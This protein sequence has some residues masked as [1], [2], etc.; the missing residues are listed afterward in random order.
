MRENNRENNLVNLSATESAAL[1]ERAE[2]RLPGGVNS[3]VRAF[4]GVGGH[5]RFIASAKGSRIFDED[6]NSYIDYVGSWGPALFGHGDENILEAVV[7]SAARG[8]SFGAPTRLEVEMAETLCEMIP[9][10]DMVRMVNS[11]TE[12]VMST[13]RLARGFTGRDLIVK[14][15]GCYHGHSDSMLVAAGSGAMTQ[16]VPDSLGVPE[17]AAKD[18]LTLPYNDIREIEKCFDKFGENISS[19]IVEPVA[20]NMGVVL[21]EEGFLQALRDITARHGAL[22]IFDEVITGFRLSAGGAQEYFSVSPDLATFGKIV[23][24][25]MPVGAYGGRADIMKC[26]APLGGVYQAGTL[27][28]NPVAM[29]AGLAALKKIKARGASLYASLEQKAEALAS[30]LELAAADCGID[31]RAPRTVGL[32][33]IF[34]TENTPLNRDMVMNCDAS[35]Y[36]KFFHGMLSRGVYFAPSAYEAFFLSDAHSAED[37]G[38]TIGAAREVFEEMRG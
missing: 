35:L 25:G 23:G 9:S 14:F 37:I 27:S 17:G 4:R 6:G 13:I 19:V 7:S 8:L 26:I 21:P 31:V 15:A 22:L 24:A 12:A 3:P 32:G 10:F 1:F 28:G 36:S 34:F 5:P 29:A 38:R 18:T 30:G 33:S 20:A 16:G 2:Q 11:G